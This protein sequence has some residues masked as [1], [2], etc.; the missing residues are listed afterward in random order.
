MR[1]RLILIWLDVRLLAVDLAGAGISSALCEKL[2]GE[3]F[4]WIIAVSA[5]VAG[6]SL[7]FV[8]QKTILP[9][10]SNYINQKLKKWKIIK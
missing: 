7:L 10:L 1:E 3:A 9:V 4:H 5:T 6:G 8:L 2:L